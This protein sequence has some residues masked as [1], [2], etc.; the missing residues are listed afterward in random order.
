MQHPATLPTDPSLP[1]GREA[2]L[3]LSDGRTISYGLYAAA[4]GPLVVVLDGPGSRGLGRA[5]AATANTVGVTLLV[6]DRPGFG[7]STAAPGRAIVDVAGDLLVLVRSLD[8]ERFGIVAQSGGTP[9]ALALA[10]AAGDSV[11]GLSF[12]GAIVPLN[13]PDA[14]RDV[15]GPMR[16]MFTM[17]RRAPWL[18]RPMIGAVARKTRRNPEAAARAYAKDLPDSDRAVLEDPTMWAIHAVTSAEAVSSP[19]AFAREA[20]LLAQP[21]GVS[22]SSV[23][24]PGAFWVG[25]LD[26]THPP[27]MSRRMA[28]RLGDAPVT[29]VPDAAT[30]GMV[31]VY[32]D[33]LSHAAGLSQPAQT[34]RRHP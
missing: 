19:A 18:L 33:V 24:A 2:D 9:Y 29:V 32:P 5:L 15:R 26:P 27:V 20:R 11:T 12:V 4:D 25:E 22:M 10:A 30:F 23:T 28:Q 6:P 13:E 14:L 8:V 31:S 34:S 16:T 7:N 3:R 17:A 21:W 1:V